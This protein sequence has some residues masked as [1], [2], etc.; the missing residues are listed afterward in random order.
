[1]TYKFPVPL[2]YIIYVVSFDVKGSMV[3]G[4]PLCIVST[5]PL[6]GSENEWAYFDCDLWMYMCHWFR[7]SFFSEVLGEKRDIEGNVRSDV[8]FVW[9][10]VECEMSGMRGV[11]WI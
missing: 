6:L 3:E 10:C 1:M 4:H 9:L 8:W 7:R 2:V 5:C 11:G